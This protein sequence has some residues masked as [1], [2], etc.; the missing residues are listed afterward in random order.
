MENAC[1]SAET[2]NSFIVDGSA[3]SIS[4]LREQFRDADP[5]FIARNKGN[6]KGIDHFPKVIGWWSKRERKFLSDCIDA[7]G[8]RGQFKERSAA[9]GHSV[10]K[11]R[12]AI[13]FSLGRRPT[14]V[15][16]SKS[17]ISARQRVSSN[18]L[19]P[20]WHDLNFCELSKGSLWGRWSRLWKHNAAS[21]FFVQLGWATRA[22]RTPIDVGICEWPST[23]KKISKAVLT[24]WWWVN[25][26]VQHPKGDWDQWQALA[27]A[28]LNNATGATA[29][30]KLHRL[31]WVW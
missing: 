1:P 19:C 29:A 23:A 18:M 9:I 16:N 6:R 2:S 8:S 22:P 17:W 5:V 24:R 20:A 4:W 11:F 3:D 26:A 14:V 7:D 21:S 13:T 27:Q 15:A 30:G 10:K 31:L 28:A 12:N 25:V